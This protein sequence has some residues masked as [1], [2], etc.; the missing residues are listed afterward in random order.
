MP[1]HTGTARAI[2]F[3]ELSS[4]PLFSGLPLDL[5]QLITSSMVR[6]YNND[7]SICSQNEVAHNLIV[8]LHGSVRIFADETY[9]LT[10]QAYEVIGEQA[11]ISNT[12]RT[13]TV[14]AQGTVKA[15]VLPRSLVEHLM[16][17]ATFT[18]NLLKI[19]SEK[20]TQATNERAFRYRNEQLLFSE[21][22]A[23]VSDGV[24][25]RLLA[26][27]MDYGKPRYIEGIILLSDIRNFT[28][29][30]ATMSPEQIG[31]QLSLYLDAVVDVIHAHDGMVNQ[32]TGD[33]VM[34]VW[35]F[36]AET[37]NPEESAFTCAR[38]MV[39]LARRMC[40]A[41]EPISIGVGLNVGRVFMGNIGGE[42]KRQFV[43][44]GSPVNLAARFESE[45]KTLDAPIVVGEAFYQSLPEKI[46]VLLTAHPNQSIKGAEAQTL[47]T[48]IPKNEQEN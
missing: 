33:A 41:D 26:S 34:A 37:K 35:G 2:D 24:T 6:F 13:A 18:R 29:R 8:L 12:L 39:A 31:E 3:S 48:Y 45:S 46:Q 23:H 9:L 38:E 16:E 25:Q 7:E 15:L 40:F 5:L 20:L 42:G 10:R 1:N 21:F 32:F 47:Y 30:C 4:L 43:V 27:G 44:I 14:F 28:P 36:D 17:N 19:V 11:L 22:R